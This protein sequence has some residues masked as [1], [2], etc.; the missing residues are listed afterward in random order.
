MGH[1]ILVSEAMEQIQKLDPDAHLRYSA[2]TKKWYVSA[3]KID[4]LDGGVLR[5]VGRHEN[6]PEEAVATLFKLLQSPPQGLR[7]VT[8]AFKE[9]R[10]YWTWISESAAWRI[11]KY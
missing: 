6:T 9:N 1:L 8:N 3:T 4:L 7:V 10:A 2:F 5:S 11:D